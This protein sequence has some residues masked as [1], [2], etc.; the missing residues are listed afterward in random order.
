MKKINTI[1]ADL[2]I[3]QI[4]EQK[5]NMAEIWTDSLAYVENRPKYFNASGPITPPTKIWSGVVT[6][7]TGNGYAIDI[8]SAGFESLT[9]VLITPFKFTSTPADVPRVAIKTYTTTAIIVNIVDSNTA[10][11]ANLTNLYLS[12]EVKGN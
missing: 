12:V 10:A 7:N 9:S 4:P 1:G 2:A 11:F 5:P 3:S 6:P 8:S